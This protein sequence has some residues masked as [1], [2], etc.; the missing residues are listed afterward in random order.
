MT[1]G[2]H[3]TLGFSYSKV[4]F[5]LSFSQSDSWNFSS[6]LITIIQK[7][8]R[9]FIFLILVFS[10]INIYNILQKIIYNITLSILISSENVW[11][12]L[13]IATI[14][15]PPSSWRY[16]LSLC[17]VQC[18]IFGTTPYW[19]QTFVRMLCSG[20]TPLMALQG[21]LEYPL[22]RTLSSLEPPP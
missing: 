12:M 22:L 16:G 3:W 21:S 6:L 19:S 14:Y 4:A 11:S 17:R 15:F 10:K 7:R 18:C 9:L 5:D 2:L 8:W 20:S 13:R 1:F